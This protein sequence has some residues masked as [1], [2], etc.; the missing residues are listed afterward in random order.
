MARKGL[1]ACD[2]CSTWSSYF[3]LG[4][5]RAFLHEGLHPWRDGRMGQIDVAALHLGTDRLC[6][7]HLAAVGAA[8]RFCSAWTRALRLLIGSA[9]VPAK[10]SPRSRKSASGPNCRKWGT[11]CE[12]RISVV[13]GRH[14][15]NRC[16]DKGERCMQS[17]ATPAQFAR[18]HNILEL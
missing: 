18:Q 6:S 16:W 15:L 13:N 1:R 14:G 3:P 4:K 9:M 17:W 2:I 7:R 5:S 12:G 8:Q 10:G 11:G